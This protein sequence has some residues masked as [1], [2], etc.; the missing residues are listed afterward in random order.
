MSS[1]HYF[2]HQIA[3][4]KNKMKI[5]QASRNLLIT[6]EFSCGCM[7]VCSLVIG[8]FMRQLDIKKKIKSGHNSNLKQ[9][10]DEFFE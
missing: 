8:S 7:C 2:I 10:L 3:S 4:D 1:D 9:S 6:I 5:D